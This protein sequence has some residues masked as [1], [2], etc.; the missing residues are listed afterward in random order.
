MLLSLAAPK[1]SAE[2]SF[3]SESP[4]LSSYSPPFLF[5]N[6]GADRLRFSIRH[7]AF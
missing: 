1:A 4:V 7:S 6:R 3:F 2:F 5:H